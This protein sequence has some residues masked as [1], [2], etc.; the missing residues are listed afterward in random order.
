MFLHSYCKMAVYNLYSYHIQVV[1]IL[2]TTKK[3]TTIR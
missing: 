2:N 1:Y 3:Y